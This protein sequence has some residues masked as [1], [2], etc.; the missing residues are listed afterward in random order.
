MLDCEELETFFDS[1]KLEK[2]IQ[3][4]YEGQKMEKFSVLSVRKKQHSYSK[5]DTILAGDVIEVFVKGQKQDF[6]RNLFGVGKFD[7]GWLK[8]FV[9]NQGFLKNLHEIIG[10]HSEICRVIRNT[11]GG[12][13]PEDVFESVRMGTLERWGAGWAERK[14]SKVNADADAKEEEGETEVRNE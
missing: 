11:F 2:L 14:H 6:Q 4:N 1:E 5:V 10:Y 7:F 12:T 8:F 13:C 3:K 9:K